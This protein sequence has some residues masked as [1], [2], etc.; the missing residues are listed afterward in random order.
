MKNSEFLNV[1]ADLTVNAENFEIA[2]AALKLQGEIQ[3]AEFQKNPLVWVLI[4]K[5]ENKA[6]FNSFERAIEGFKNFLIKNGKSNS[7]N[8]KIRE[9]KYVGDLT[10]EEL[11]ENY[12][13]N[14]LY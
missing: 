11:F 10:Y 6:Y 5:G 2:L 8:L 3:K 7:R 9:F 14:L 4:L 1:L 12:S 13:I